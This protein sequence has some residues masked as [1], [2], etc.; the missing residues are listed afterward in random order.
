MAF[1]D[2][3]SDAIVLHLCHHD[4]SSRVING[5]TLLQRSD[6]KNAVA[7]DYVFGGAPC[8]AHLQQLLNALHHSNA[9]QQRQTKAHHQ[10]L[11]F[12]HAQQ[13]RQQHE[14]FVQFR[15]SSDSPHPQPKPL[16]S[17]L[18]RQQETSPQPASRAW[19]SQACA[20]CHCEPVISRPLMSA[21]LTDEF[22][23]TG[24]FVLPSQQH[25]KRSTCMSHIERDSIGDHC[26][27]IGARLRARLATPE[28]FKSC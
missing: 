25:E 22:A 19:G 6:G 18:T 12:P 10:T 7:F 28:S 15:C 20:P 24:C 27:T 16:P 3:P 17:P 13:Q 2:H 14:Q 9:C 1:L 11:G 21:A 8:H 5:K 23:E 26:G 4:S